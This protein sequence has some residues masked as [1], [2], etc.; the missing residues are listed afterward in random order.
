[1][2]W[3]YDQKLSQDSVQLERNGA[4]VAAIVK[5][6]LHFYE[7]IIWSALECACPAWHSSSIVEQSSR[8]DVQR[9]S[10]NFIYGSAY[11]YE[12]ICRD[13]CHESDRREFLCKCFFYATKNTDSCLNYRLLTTR[14]YKLCNCSLQRLRNPQNLVVDR[15][16]RSRYR[17]KLICPSCVESISIVIGIAVCHVFAI[18]GLHSKV[19]TFN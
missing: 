18:L 14:N 11:H 13:N 16:R 12:H 2:L 15:P 17:N 4:T 8:K 10:F 19:E 9:R 7:S 1:M 6:M 3:L 5:D